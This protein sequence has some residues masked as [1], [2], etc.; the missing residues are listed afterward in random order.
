MEDNDDR[1]FF[2]DYLRIDL[3]NVEEQRN[4]L[5]SKH[6]NLVQELNTCKEQLLVLKKTKLDLL[7]MQHANTEILKENQNL[8]NELKELTSITEAWLN[9]SNKVNQSPARGNKSS[10]AS[11]TNSAPASKL[12]N[13]KIED[14]PPLAIV[15]KEHNELKLQISKNNNVYTTSDHNDIEWFRKREALQ[16]K[17]VE[18]FKASKTESS[19]ALR[20]KTPTKK[21]TLD[22]CQL[23]EG[24]KPEAKTRQKKRSTSSKQPFMSNKEGKKYGSSK[25]PTGSKTGHLKRKKESSSAIDSNLSQTS[26]STLVVAKMHKEDQQATSSPTSLGVTNDASLVSIA[27]AD[28][29]KSVPS[30]DTHVFVDKTQSIIEGLEAVLTY[31]I[32]GKGDSSIA[33]QVEEDEDSRTIKLEDLAKLVS[34]IQ[35][36]FKDLDSPKDDTIIIVDD[37]DKDEEANEVHATT[38]VVTKDPSVPKSSSPSSLL[39]ELKDLPSK[40]NEL[41]EEV[42]GLKKQVHELDIELPSNLKEIPSKLEDFTKTV[43]IEMVQAKLK[44]LNALSSLLNKVTNVLNQFA[45]VSASKN[46]GYTIVPLAGQVGTQPA[47]GEKNTNQATISQ[48]FQRKAAK[49]ANLTKQQSKPTPPPTTL[50]IPLVITTTTQMQSYS[51]QIESSITKKLKKF[52]FIT[53]NGKHIHLTKEQINQQNKIEEEA[54]AKA[55]KQESE[56]RK[57]ELVDLLG[58][59]VVNKYYNDKLQFDKYCD[60]MLNRRAKSR[61]TNCDVLTKKGPITPKVY[62]EDGTSEVVPNFKA[63]DLYLGEWREVVK[64]CPNRTDPL[65][66]LNDLANKKRKHDG[67]IHDYFKE[68]KR[69][70]SS[71]QYEDHLPGTMLNEP[72]LGMIICHQ[73]LGLDDH[74]RTFSSLLLAKVDKRNLNPLKQI[75]VIKQLRGRGNGDDSHDS[76][77]SKRRQVPT[78][79]ECTNNDFLKCQPL[80]FKVGN[81]VKFS[82]CTLLGN[83]LMRWNS[84]VKTISHEAYGMT[85]KTL[86]KIMTDKYYPRGEIKKL[87]IELRNLKVKGTDVVSYT[88][89]Y[90][91]LALMRGRMFPEESDEVKKYVGGLPDM[92]QGS[93]MASK[94]K[95]MQEA[96]ESPTANANDNN[97][98][99]SEVNQRVVTSFK[100]GVQGHYKKDC[101]KLKNNNRGNQA[102]N[103]GAQ[104]RAYAVGNAGKTRTPR[105]LQGCTLNFLNHPFNTDLIPVELGSFDVIIS[106]DWLSMY[107]AIIVC[108][109]NIIRIPFGNEIL[110]VHG[111]GSNNRHESRL[112]IISYTKTQK[113]LLKGCHVFLA[114]VTIKKAEDKSEEKRLEDVPIQEHEEH[115]KLILE[116]LQ[117]EEMIGNFIVYFDASHKVLGPV[118]MQN[119]KVIAYASRQLKIHEKN[120]TTHDLELGVVVFALKIWIHNMYGTKCTVFTEHKILQHILDQ[121][122]LNMRQRHWLELLSDYDCEIRYHPGKANVVADERKPENFKAEDVGG[123]IRKDKLEARADETLCLSNRSWLPCYNDQRTLIMHESH[124]SKYF[125]HLGSDKMYQDMKKLYWCPNM[126]ADITTYVSKCL[127]CLKT[128]GQSKRTIQTLEDMLCACVIDFGNGWDRHLPLIKFSYKNSYHT[129]IKTTPFEALYVRKCRSPV[130]WAEKSYADVRRKPLE[131]QVGDKV[132]LKVSPCKGVIRFGK[133]GKLNPS[134]I[135]PFKVLAKVGTVAYRIEL[136]QQLT[137]VHSTFHVSI[138]KKCLSD[139]LLVIPLDEIHTNDK[140]HD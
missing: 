20:S 91:E 23:L 123:M 31:P 74:A 25:A 106:M 127:T 9:S 101:P 136:P 77:T 133:R 58:S 22:A 67:D 97:Q 19:S 120:Y 105:S 42:K 100:H 68:N 84:Y 114:H 132:M 45:Q 75:R 93:V 95:T 44:T 121:K 4:N 72:V 134:Y 39:T 90:Q 110:I 7:T 66:K 98:R 78:T 13:V 94:P 41:T 131:F 80:N 103:G 55:S 10:S 130:C 62:I 28:P 5:T 117:K 89:R 60:K 1:K 112:N 37:N 2:L 3:N 35:P 124:K 21:G 34:R 32:T 135:R 8:R 56:V 14:D 49:N 6:R 73:G 38:N 81:Q 64:A 54:K 76:R 33:R 87:E 115:L 47:K 102:G 40:F 96:I 137:R 15:M 122:E 116:L 61:I 107:H 82:K 129:S 26:V 128:D 12:K 71:V 70:K 126:K 29:K 65:D 139:E 111:D 27:K 83:A 30:I 18:S 17:K 86:K 85:Q 104:A 43:K 24:T 48:L 109:E 36:S 50:T 108:D 53:E 113:Y 99:N 51:L 69:L 88:Q 119:E 16:D 52:D 125:V 57:E 63:S 140:L 59:E 92:I 11:K 46:I 118:L 138:L 79:H